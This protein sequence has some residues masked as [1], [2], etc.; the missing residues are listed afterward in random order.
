MSSRKKCTSYYGENIRVLNEFEIEEISN[1][2]SKEPHVNN[3]IVN[4]IQQLVLGI[5][6]RDKKHRSI[7]AETTFSKASVHNSAINSDHLWLVFKQGKLC[8]YLSGS[9][10]YTDLG[11]QVYV[12]KACMVAEEVDNKAELFSRLYARQIIRGVLSY[13]NSANNLGKPMP[14]I[15]RTLNPVVAQTVYS[16]G[17]NMY[18]DLNGLPINDK[19][20]DRHRAFE[21]VINES[22]GE[23]GILINNFLKHSDYQLRSMKGKSLRSKIHSFCRSLGESNGAVL[24]GEL[25][26]GDDFIRHLQ[27]KSSHD[28]TSMGD[29]NLVNLL[30]NSSLQL[31]Q[32]MYENCVIGGC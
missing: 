15:T 16:L 24:T 20:R 32:A 2:S 3:L 18:P 28:Q 25:V 11:E 4:D 10:I 13:W 12:F 27:D 22:I 31:T 26:F 1:P 9:H 14:F 7:L 29:L 8:A 6:A 23:D 17:T 30:R 5:Y 21:K 19:I